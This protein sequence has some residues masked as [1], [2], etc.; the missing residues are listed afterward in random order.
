MKKKITNNKSS[1]KNTIEKM[2]K[3]DPN[4]K[5]TSTPDCKVKSPSKSSKYKK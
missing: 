4:K 3:N 5:K 2:K 1:N